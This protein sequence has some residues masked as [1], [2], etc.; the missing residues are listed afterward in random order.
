MEGGYDF[1][2][3][4]PIPAEY[5]CLI[6]QMLLREATELPC[7]HIYCKNCLVRWEDK[8]LNENKYV[9]ENN[10]DG[11]SVYLPKQTV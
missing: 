5:V 1:E 4:D 8:T 6:C 3:V 9:L 7:T 10:I 11:F 2:T